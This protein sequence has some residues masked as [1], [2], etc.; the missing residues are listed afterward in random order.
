MDFRRSEAARVRFQPGR[1]R[2]DSTETGFSGYRI[3]SSKGRDYRSDS[4]EGNLLPAH[5]EFP[6]SENYSSSGTAST[7]ASNYNSAHLDEERQQPRLTHGQERSKS[8]Q[9]SSQYVSHIF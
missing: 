9:S 3:V 7:S 5:K 4:P 1:E 2:N 8:T 6:W